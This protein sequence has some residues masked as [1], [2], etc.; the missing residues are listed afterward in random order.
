MAAWHPLRPACDPGLVYQHCAP[1]HKERLCAHGA[2]SAGL[3]RRA[4]SFGCTFFSS[5]RPLLIKPLPR[6]WVLVPRG[7][8]ERHRE[9]NK[10]RSFFRNTALP[11]R[12]ERD[13]LA[14]SLPGSLLCLFPPHLKNSNNQGAPCPCGIRR[15][16]S[17]RTASTDLN[18]SK[19]VRMKQCCAERASLGRSQRTRIE[20]HGPISHGCELA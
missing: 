5:F 16:D 8:K 13:T 20:S 11:A 2:Y 14:S 12:A 9:Q 3:G 15:K 6:P 17:L 4:L 1:A 18:Y 10:V 19:G 7:V